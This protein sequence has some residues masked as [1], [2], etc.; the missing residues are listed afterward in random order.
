MVVHLQPAHIRFIAALQADQGAGVGVTHGVGQQVAEGALQQLLVGGQCAV[1]AVFEP[2]V[3]I[4]GQGFKVIA[5]FVAD[6]AQ[7]QCLQIERAF[8]LLG[9]GE[10][11]KVLGHALE[12]FELFHV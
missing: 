11:H 4:I 8:G 9:A 1:H 3:A 2:K 10:E 5:E 12:P 6:T 7:V